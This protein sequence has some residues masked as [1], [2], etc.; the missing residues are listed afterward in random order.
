MVT[1]IVNG[2]ILAP[3]GIQHGVLL[4]EDNRIKGIDDTVPAR[5]AVIDA[6]G[7]YVAPGFIDMHTHVPGV[8]RN[9]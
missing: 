6:E 5:A 7:C 2:R 8:K 3:G 9:V 1:A 4:L